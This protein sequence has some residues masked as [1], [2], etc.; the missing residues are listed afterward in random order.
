M[1]TERQRI[2]AM[3]AAGTISAEEG[4]ELLRAMGAGTVG[5]EPPTDL[6]LRHD[7][8]IPFGAGLV[9]SFF[10]I[11]SLLRRERGIFASLGA[12]AT[13]LLGL[14][15]TGVGLSGRS[16]PWLHVRVQQKEG[17]N[18]HISFPVPLPLAEALLGLARPYVDEE[19]GRYLDG[20]SEFLQ[21]LRVGDAREPFSVEIE[22]DDGEQVLIYLG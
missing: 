2:M 5:R 14:L 3:V 19:T 10:G 12:W 4:D 20:A 16:S 1:E 21:T 8:E 15:V 22:G 17:A 9:I 11:A 18:V 13:L 6:P 7:W